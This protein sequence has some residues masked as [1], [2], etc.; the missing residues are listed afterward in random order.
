MP[1]ANDCIQTCYSP[2]QKQAGRLEI[3]RLPG[4]VQLLPIKQA[5]PFKKG[6]QQHFNTNVFLLI[7]LGLQIKPINGG[8]RC[9]SQLFCLI[10]LS[11]NV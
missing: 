4:F 2:R 7:A 5:Y 10:L 1:D 8:V 11:D 3:L 9:R 6:Q